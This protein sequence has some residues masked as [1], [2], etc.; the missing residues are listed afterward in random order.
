MVAR[1][2]DGGDS[3]THVEALDPTELSQNHLSIHPPHLVLRVPSP[4]FVPIFKRPPLATPF[5]PPSTPC[6]INF[7]G[8]S[9][10]IIIIVEFLHLFPP[11]S[12]S[13]PIHT[14]N[15]CLTT[16][17]DDPS[18]LPS[19][20]CFYRVNLVKQFLKTCESATQSKGKHWELIPTE[21][22]SLK[23]NHLMLGVCCHCLTGE[24]L[25]Y[26]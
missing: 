4:L 21:I 10:I 18:S 9:I 1:A 8:T 15:S 24:S 6:L 13:V 22:I 7:W 26:Y 2:S 12:L 19:S 20:D 25:G 3:N 16:I 14:W 23:L 5:H 17:C 11:C